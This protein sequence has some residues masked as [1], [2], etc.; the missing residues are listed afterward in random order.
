MHWDEWIGPAPFR[1]FHSD[2]HPHEWHGW[3]D[4][5]NGSL[6][7]MSCHVLDGVYWALKVEHPVSV[8]AEWLGAA[9]SRPANGFIAITGKR[10]GSNEVDS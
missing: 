3:V 6:G 9:A 1:D 7:N 4:F 5:G 10:L 2:L 8:E